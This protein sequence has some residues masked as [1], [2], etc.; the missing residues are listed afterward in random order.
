MKNSILIIS[1][2]LAFQSCIPAEKKVDPLEYNLSMPGQYFR[3]KSAIISACDTCS[4]G[5]YKISFPFAVNPD[6]FQKWPEG[7]VD[8]FDNDQYSVMVRLGLAFSHSEIIK[9]IIDHRLYQISV[10]NNQKS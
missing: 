9:K 8:I 7:V 10:A 3:Y 4:P 2:L 5:V 6:Q 1:C